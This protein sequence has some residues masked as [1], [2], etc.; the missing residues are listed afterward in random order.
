[1]AVTLFAH[2]QKAYQ[3][4]EAMLARTGKVA[5]VHPTG[6][7]KSFIAFKLIEDNPNKTFLW[8][9]PSEYIFKTQCESVQ[10]DDPLSRCKTSLL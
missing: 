5:V 2:N 1:M 9:S 4:V 10:R 8:L 3:S 6:T 7:G